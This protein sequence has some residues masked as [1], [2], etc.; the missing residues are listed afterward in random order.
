MPGAADRILKMA[1]DTAEHDRT[2]EHE[3]LKLV[4]RETLLGQIFAVLIAIIAIG[5]GT[6]TAVQGYQIAGAAISSVGVLGI[7]TA[8]IMGKTGDQAVSKTKVF[9][10]FFECLLKNRASPL[11]VKARGV[12]ANI[13]NKN[14]IL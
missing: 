9:W 5:C 13:Q 14:W 12:N 1:E 8:F 6:Y 11:A 7:V 4:G 10:V 3:A 2:V